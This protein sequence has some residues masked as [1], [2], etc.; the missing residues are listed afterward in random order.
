[1]TAM[2]YKLPAKPER[3]SP[4]ERIPRIARLLAL[5][6]KLQ[7]CCTAAMWIRWRSRRGSD[8]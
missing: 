8:G 2:R 4:S 6:Q 3:S 5:A 7:G 1:M